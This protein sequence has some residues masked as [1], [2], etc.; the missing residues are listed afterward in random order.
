MAWPACAAPWRS[1]CRSTSARCDAA[2]GLHHGV[3]GRLGLAG[4]VEQQRIVRSAP[5]RKVVLPGIAIPDVPEGDP[6]DGVATFEI[7][8]EQGGVAL[9]QCLLDGVRQTGGERVG[10]GRARGGGRNVGGR[11]PVGGGQRVHIAPRGAVRPPVS[12]YYAEANLRR[13][14]ANSSCIS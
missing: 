2:R 1:S 10:V 12:S 8:A 6:G 14:S 11:L 4:A 9:R 3:E 13:R 7:R 5:D